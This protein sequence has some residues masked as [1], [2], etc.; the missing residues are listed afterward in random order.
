MAS[1]DAIPSNGYPKGKVQDYVKR[2]ENVEEEIATAKGSFMRRVGKF[3]QD[4]A[5]ILEE[6]KSNGIPRKALRKVLKARKLERDAEAVREDL[7]TEEQDQFDLLRH[8]L[9][10]LD[11]DKVVNMALARAKKR[12]SEEEAV[13]ST[14][15]EGEKTKH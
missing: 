13:D 12:A 3:R 1:T 15:G 7:E 9:G 5:D 11:D 10:D 14:A 4:Q 8:A 6:A 2:F